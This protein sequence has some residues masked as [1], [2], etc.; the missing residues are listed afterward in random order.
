MPISG[1]HSLYDTILPYSLPEGVVLGEK[2]LIF[3]H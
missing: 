3:H 2:N 1:A